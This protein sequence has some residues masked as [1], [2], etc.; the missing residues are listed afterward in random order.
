MWWQITAAANA[1]VAIAYIMISAAIVRPLIKTGQLRSNRLGTATAAIFLTCAVHHGGHSVHMVLPTFG[2]EEHSGLALREA[3]GWHQ[4]MWD[5]VTA[6]V[7][8]YYWSLRRTYSSLMRGAALFDDLKERER[9]AL[10]LH[11]E[12]VQGL[13]VAKLAL[14]LDQNQA[15]K[16]ALTSTLAA[17]SNIIDELIGKTREEEHRLVAG[18]L[19]R[20]RPADIPRP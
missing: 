11:D 12:V 2:L 15:S 9:Q 14:D 18:D 19:V 1:L 8:V 10:Q 13:V 20:E 6:A 3:F 17:A 16:E 5:I 7:G 4:A